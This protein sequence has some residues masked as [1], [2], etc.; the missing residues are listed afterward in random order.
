MARP[1]STHPTNS[2][3]AILQILWR[4]GPMTVREVHD[5]VAAES[6]VSYT[7]VLKTM[8]IML[9]KGLLARDP[10][11]RQH[12]YRARVTQK[13]TQL[14]ILRDVL[15]KAFE[16]SVAKLVLGAIQ[17]KATTEEELKEIQ[18]IIEEH[19]K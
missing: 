7:T 4:S 10:S 15:D 2:E 5:A 13:K 19:A 12:I 17:S 14:K 1:K 9:E 16:G 8:Q 6:G 18:K 3:L 11:R